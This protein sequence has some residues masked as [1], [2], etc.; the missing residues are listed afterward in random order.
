MYDPNQARPFNFLAQSRTYSLFISHAWEYGEEYE[1]VVHLLNSDWLFRWKNLSVP[2]EHPL[3]T[4]IDL[5]KSYRF[6][7]RQIDALISQSDC[8]VVVAGMYAAH[9][10]WIQSEIESAIDFRK[11]IIGIVPRGNEK[12]PIAV[13]NAATE[14]VGWNS[15]SITAAIRRHVTAPAPQ[16]N[17]MFPIKNTTL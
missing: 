7:V 12:I 10:G 8:L 14:I 5:P 6:L 15:A 4:L 2:A 11:P 13:Q 1:G 3:P 16:F 9:R 17:S